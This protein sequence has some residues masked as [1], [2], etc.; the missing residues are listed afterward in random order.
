[1]T[2]RE[3]ESA[4]VRRR[5]PASSP[6][7]ARQHERAIDKAADIV[8]DAFG[9]RR[10]ISL[11]SD[12]DDQLDEAAAYEI[13]SR[14]HARRV[15]R[16]ETPIGRKIGLTN[17]T[18]WPQYGVRA[19]IWGHV[20]DSTTVRAKRDAAEVPIGHLI[21]P[22]IEPEIQLHFASTPPVTRD[23][24][25]ILECIDWIAQGFEIV[26]CPFADWTFTAADA[27]AA[28]A[29]HGAL[30]VG[31]PVPVSDIDDCAAK[32]R[33]FTIALARDG[34][35]VAT[36]CGANVLD[37]PLSAFAHLAEVLAGQSRFQPVQAGEVI[38]TGTL[39]DVLPAHPGQ[40]WSTTTDGIG[41]PALSITLT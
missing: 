34:A 14:V 28:Y 35:R 13:A 4:A 39:T 21:Q 31:T 30:I 36:G 29:V 3:D 37:S 9:S 8:L 38:T 25:A 16:G 32:L 22:R 10:L 15:H 11:L 18:I 7:L 19:P 23:E 27:I 6:E 1:L 2:G 12:S 40:T 5:A 41:L 20:Y 26:Q 17:R 24:A 33:A